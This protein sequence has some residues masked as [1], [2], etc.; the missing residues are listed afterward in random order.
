MLAEG[1]WGH[2]TGA[3]IKEFGLAENRE[4]QVWELGVKEVWKVQK[5]LDRVIH[6]LG[7]V[8]AEGRRQVRRSSA[9]RGSTR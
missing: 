2:L 6:T 3:A 1:C 9:A 8:A 7:A 5:P 4:P